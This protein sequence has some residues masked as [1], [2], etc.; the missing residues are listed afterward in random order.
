MTLKCLTSKSVPFKRLTLKHSI[1]NHSF[2][3]FSNLSNL[4]KYRPSELSSIYLLSRSSLLFCSS[5]TFLFSR[6]TSAECSLSINGTFFWSFSIFCRD[7]SLSRTCFL[8]SRFS[9]NSS[10]HRFVDSPSLNTIK[11]YIGIR[12]FSSTLPTCL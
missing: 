2:L 1:K 9:S 7:F 3:I 6:R 12:R 10:S 4:D 8:K 11:L 5:S